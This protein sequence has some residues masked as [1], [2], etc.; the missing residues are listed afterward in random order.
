MAELLIKGTKIAEK[1][2]TETTVDVNNVNA[3]KL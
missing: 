1:I 3:N 2:G